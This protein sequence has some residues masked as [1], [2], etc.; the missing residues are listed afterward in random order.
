MT[1]EAADVEFS[2]VVRTAAITGDA[3][4]LANL[5]RSDRPLGS[6]ERELLAALVMGQLKAGR[7]KPE[8]GR[9]ERIRQWKAV[10]KYRAALD[11]GELEKNVAVDVAAK[12]AVS[13]STLRSWVT[14]INQAEQRMQDLGL[15][16]WRFSD[17]S[18]LPANSD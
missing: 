15:A 5:L 18:N 12:E 9:R 1:S 10:R 14:S 3:A 6:A 4:E 13:V 11:R 7:G 2:R 17:W 8:S 16:N